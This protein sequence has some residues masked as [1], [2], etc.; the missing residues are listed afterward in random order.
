MSDINKVL[1]A[2]SGVRARGPNKWQAFCPNH[3][4][5]KRSLSI[6]YL[7][8]EDR[9]L[10]NCFAECNIND[11]LSA[12]GL[13]WADLMPEKEDKPLEKWQIDLEAEYRFRNIKGEYG[14]SKLRYKD[15]NIRFGRTDGETFLPG[16]GDVESML[17]CLPELVKGIRAGKTVI[18]TEGEKDVDNLRNK[19]LTATTAGS[20]SDWKSH[21]ADYFIGA[22][23]VLLPDND[24]PGRK[25]MKE[26]D[27]DLAPVAYRRRTVMTSE[28]EKGDVTDWL[29]EGH[30]RDDLLRLID[31]VEPKYPPWLPLDGKKHKVNT[32][33]LAETILQRNSVIVARNPGTN[34]DIVFWFEHGVYRQKSEAEVIAKVNPYL[35]AAVSNP[36]VLK[37][38][39]TMIRLNAEPYSFDDINKGEKY[40][41]VQNGLLDVRSE[42]L[43]EH[44]PD[45]I[46]SIQL[47]CKYDEN[48]EA[49]LW[50]KFINDICS[51][52]DGA[53]DREM[54]DMLQEWT[55]MILSPIHGYRLKK[56]L[57]LFSP[58]GNTGKT[59][60]LKV[61]S[62]LLGVH[63]IANVSFQELGS[64]RWATG[65]AFGKRLLAVGDQSAKA[66]DSSSIFKQLT[67]GDL[68]SAEFKGLQGFDYQFTGVMVAACNALP[69][70][71]DDKGNHVSERLQFVPFRHTVPREDRDPDLVDKL[72]RERDGILRWALAGLQR[73]INNKLQFSRCDSSEALMTEYRK[74]YDTLFAFVQDR[75]VLT[76]KKSDFEYKTVFESEYTSYCMKT[77]VV[78][79]KTRNIQHR[80]AG[81]GITLGTAQ[82]Y[83]VYRGVK[84]KE[85]YNPVVNDML[86]A[87]GLLADETTGREE[88]F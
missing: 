26:I 32:G 87:N 73:L 52:E 74:R 31:E 53:P 25:L 10:M 29:E 8:S 75:C 17:Y 33:L 64:S 14:Y 67:G 21:Y 60:F 6:T 40:I 45:E 71:T 4:D 82:G 59:V 88:E 78:P 51:D 46:G 42:E 47:S 22:D 69:V 56:A 44:A 27:R 28:E 70:F 23:V 35:P 54:I 43:L 72:C 36:T 68:V 9:I 80:A 86:H 1:S 55:G 63:N 48:A 37:N 39:A 34:S 77:N 66:I 62:F 41:N 16:K 61:I 13:E 5:R 12:A 57:I 83:S 18:I 11:V 84:L 50:E 79:L 65:R 20:V 76:G 81:I 49:P 3:D 15:K 19:G 58:Q 30:S 2:L 24:D 85:S 38:V 7:P